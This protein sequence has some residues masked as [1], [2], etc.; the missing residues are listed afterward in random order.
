[1]QK[2]MNKFA[3]SRAGWEIFAAHSD[4][5]RRICNSIC[6]RMVAYFGLIISHSPSSHSRCHYVHC[7][8][9]DDI[10]RTSSLYRSI[11]CSRT[12]S[13]LNQNGIFKRETCFVNIGACI[14]NNSSISLNLIIDFL[15]FQVASFTGEK[16]AIDIYN[17]LLVGAY[18]AGVSEGFA[19]GFGLG[20]VSL[21]VFSTYG[22]AVWFGGKMVLE[23]GY[24]GGAVINVIV[25][26]LTGS[27]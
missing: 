9:Q 22:M 27:L 18:K 4:V 24:S 11:C 21:V 16:R 23:K 2:L 7:D 10:S 3:L 8:I 15:I 14:S 26:V 6:E 19:S 25:A 13:W 1:M 17:K 5:Y 20:T 12:D